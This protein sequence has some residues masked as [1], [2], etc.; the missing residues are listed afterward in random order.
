MIKCSFVCFLGIAMYGQV[1]LADKKADGDPG[2]DN[3]RGL[4][5]VAVSPDQR[6]VYVAGSL[7]NGLTVFSQNSFSGALTFV[8]SWVDGMGGVTSLAA[9]RGVAISPDGLFVYTAALTD[10]A[11]T[12]FSRNP[13]TGQL[14]FV[15]AIF[16]LDTGG[17]FDG[18]GGAMDLT[19]SPDGL[20][21][22]AA[23]RSDDAVVA[24][25]RNTMMGTLALISVY[26]N[27]S[28]PG[29]GMDA[30]ERLQL[31]PD[32]QYLYVIAEQS[33]S[34]V[35]FSRD[36]MSGELGF[37]GTYYDGQGGVDGLG[38]ASDLAISPDGLNVYAVGQYGAGGSS[39]ATGFDDWLG[40]FARD[41][42]TGSLT[43]LATVDPASLNFPIGCGGVASGNGVT[44]SADGKRLYATIGWLGGFVAMD[45]NPA[46]GLLS[47]NAIECTDF[48]N[49]APLDLISAHRMAHD[50]SG[51]RFYVSALSPGTVLVY[52]NDPYHQFRT[53]VGTWPNP[54]LLVLIDYLLQIEP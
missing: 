35:S 45:R 53:G 48:V 30:P 46:S 7:D 23:A 19:I 9:V 34:I 50:G 21:L 28:G 22:Y 29:F 13:N 10:S 43:F 4:Y 11:V 33:Q 51:K 25:S 54:N 3:M 47:L 44:L 36:E 2:L 40:I 5:S 17:S 24:F 27:N 41:L 1:Y 16:D 39:C 8:E 49:P 6:S 14:T 18:L 42:D 12:V 20:H 31:S 32:G 52:E 38:C 15:Q 37:L 26:S